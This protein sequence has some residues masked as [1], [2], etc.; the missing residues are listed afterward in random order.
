MSVR[1]KGRG[2][3]RP[4]NPP[5]QVAG[6]HSGVQSLIMRRLLVTRAALSLW[7]G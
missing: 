2:E 6:F 4:I 3:T 5:G 7:R 1:K